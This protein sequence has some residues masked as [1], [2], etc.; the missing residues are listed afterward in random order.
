[1]KLWLR[2][3]LNSLLI[4]ET[5]W[6]EVITYSSSPQSVNDWSLMLPISPSIV[7]VP[8][9][10][11]AFF[12]SI[13]RIFAKIVGNLRALSPTTLYIRG[14]DLTRSPQSSEGRVPKKW[15]A[16]VLD[17]LKTVADQI[18]SSRDRLGHPRVPL[19]YI[20]NYKSMLI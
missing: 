3:N 9:S 6:N 4:Y 12:W 10:T 16:T 20:Q 13:G 8:D 1:M 18:P 11:R 17:M 2:I 5:C 15:S 7:L 14:E 19:K